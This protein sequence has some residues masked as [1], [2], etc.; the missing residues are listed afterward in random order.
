MAS[1]SKSKY[2]FLKMIDRWLNRQMI[3]RLYLER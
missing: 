1:V 2:T 3:I